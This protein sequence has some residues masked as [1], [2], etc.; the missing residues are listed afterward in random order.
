MQLFSVGGG[1]SAPPQYG[2]APAARTEPRTKR[3]RGSQTSLGSPF[4]QVPPP[5]KWGC[6]I[7]FGWVP[8]IGDVVGI[9]LSSLGSQLQHQH[10]PLSHHL[11]PPYS[12]TQWPPPSPAASSARSSR[13]SVLWTGMEFGGGGGLRRGEVGASPPRGNPRTRTRTRPLLSDLA[14]A[15]VPPK[16]DR[17]D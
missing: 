8:P 9:R 6:Y 7:I 17:P 3:Q 12:K 13:V 15:V 11:S 2:A 5:L 14:S 10:Q 4:M 16:Q 1:S